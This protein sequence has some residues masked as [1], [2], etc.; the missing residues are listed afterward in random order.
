[1]YIYVTVRSAFHHC[2]KFAELVDFSSLAFLSE[3]TACLEQQVDRLN[4]AYVFNN[5]YQY[6]RHARDTCRHGICHPFSETLHI[7]TDICVTN[8]YGV[9]RSVSSFT[10]KNISLMFVHM[11][12]NS[13]CS[14]FECK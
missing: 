13:G 3:Y 7:L 12:N 4:I 9:S 14:S 11:L 10:C 8:S 5:Q 1:M 2:H 6:R